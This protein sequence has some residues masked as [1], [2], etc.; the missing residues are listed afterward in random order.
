MVDYLIIVFILMGTCSISSAYPSYYLEYGSHILK[1][2][3]NPSGGDI[4]I[5]GVK[6][7]KTPLAL[8]NLE[9]GSHIVEIHLAD[10]DPYSKRINTPV[11]NEIKANL[12]PIEKLLTIRSIPPG[13][14]VRINN[15]LV[16]NAPV[17]EYLQSG[18]Y[19]ISLR[20]DGYE[21]IIK[22]ITISQPKTSLTIT[23]IVI[24]TSFYNFYYLIQTSRSNNLHNFCILRT[25]KKILR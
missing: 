4:L 13:A 3:S 16:G 20:L 8:T 24:R 10:Y 18:A 22:D 12:V 6:F 5:D 7:G 23:L 1:V 9:P 15:R 17:N 25:C 19:S 11:E 2:D 21:N 14:Q